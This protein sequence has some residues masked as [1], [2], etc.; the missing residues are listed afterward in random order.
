MKKKQKLLY[1]VKINNFAVEFISES[2]N[3]RNL[4]ELL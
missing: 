4:F 3:P 1:R 2:W